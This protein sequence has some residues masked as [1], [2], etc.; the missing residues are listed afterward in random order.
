M[1]CVVIHAARM[2]TAVIP[3]LFFTRV[4]FEL[5][6]TVRVP[7]AVSSPKFEGILSPNS[8]KDQKKDLHGN[9]VLPS[10]GI[11]S[12]KVLKLECIFKFISKLK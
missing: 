4:P 5:L 2:R 6:Y 1:H 8:I 12:I 9:L 11:R 7:L 10:A 3:K